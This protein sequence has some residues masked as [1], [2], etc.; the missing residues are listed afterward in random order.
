MEFSLPLA[1]LTLWFTLILLIFGNL[2]DA[3]EAF[4]FVDSNYKIT[5]LQRCDNGIEKT[6][7][8]LNWFAC[9]QPLFISAF[10]LLVTRFMLS[11]YD[12]K[13]FKRVRQQSLDS[14]RQ[15]INA[16][17]VREFKSFNMIANKSLSAD[18]KSPMS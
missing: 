17:N 6:Q 15:S 16:I 8:V 2:K 10:C 18:R 4:K 9:F 5:D 1:K 3:F 7:L 11:K 13:E 12:K 14:M